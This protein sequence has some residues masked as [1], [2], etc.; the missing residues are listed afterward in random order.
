MAKLLFVFAAL[1]VAVHG[2]DLTVTG[3][4]YVEGVAYFGFGTAVYPHGNYNGLPGTYGTTT[5][6]EVYIWSNMVVAG[7]YYD[8]VWPP[9][10]H[11]CNTGEWCYAYDYTSSS[12]RRVKTNIVERNVTAEIM[13]KM[14]AVETVTY[15]YL[16]GVNPGMHRKAAGVHTGFIAQDM[17]KV[18]PDAVVEKKNQAVTAEKS[19]F[20]YE[21]KDPL[22]M[23]M[24]NLVPH[25]VEAV[26]YLSG[27]LGDLKTQADSLLQH[28]SSA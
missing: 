23:N 14:N 5:P 7:F 27:D 21:I 8:N 15:E 1:L 13:H 12:D 24:A 16:P 2:T 28:V 26:Q 9:A 25:L 10:A 18:F 6:F 3:N 22:Y 20:Q 11:P 4:L 19:G 17:Q